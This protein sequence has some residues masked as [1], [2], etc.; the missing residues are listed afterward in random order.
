MDYRTPARAYGVQRVLEPEGSLPQ[1][2][3]RLD[4]SSPPYANEIAIEVDRLNID[5]AS[6]HQIVGDV[7]RD[8]RAV[9]DRILEIVEARGKME[10]P[11]TG[12]GGMLIGTIGA[13]GPDYDGPVEVVVGDAVATLVSLTLTPL[14]LERVQSVDFEAHHVAV[15]GRAH[16]PPSAPVAV[17]PDDLDERVALAVLDVCGAPAR[18]KRLARDVSSLLILGAGRSGM[19]AAAAARDVLGED[20]EIRA[21]DLEPS[22]LEHLA[23]EGFVDAHRCADATDPLE[24]LEC[25]REM[26]EGGR[27]ELVVDTCNVPHTEMAS[28]LACRE[29]GTVYFFNMATDFSRAALGAEGVGRDVELVVGNGYAEGHAA[30]ALELVRRH[31]ALRERIERMVTDEA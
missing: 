5:S 1:A 19:L 2:A 18:A 4:A 24:V 9:A 3:R 7:G 25:V 26:G 31:P 13:V 10:N 27:P 14:S 12:S 8:E 16:L 17:V 20:G 11:V 23:D 6:F 15:E 30:Y 29:R 22:N 21:I 28:I